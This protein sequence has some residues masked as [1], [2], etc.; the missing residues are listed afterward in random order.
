MDWRASYQQ[1]RVS[2]EEAVKRIKSGD[3]VVVTHATGESTLLSEAMVKNAAQYQNV[4]VV[5]M[6]AMGKAEYCQP[7]MSEH[8]RHNSLFVGGT[9]RQAIADGPG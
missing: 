1:K 4:E 7:E 8:F 5:H 9:T 3:R 2:A 6:V